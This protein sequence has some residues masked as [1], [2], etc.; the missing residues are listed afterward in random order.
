MHGEKEALVDVG[1]AGDDVGRADFS[2]K[3]D[4]V[5]EGF[6]NTPPVVFLTE[7]KHSFPSVVGNRN[8]FLKKSFHFGEVNF[9]G[10]VFGKTI[11]FYFQAKSFEDINDAGRA[12]NKRGFEIGS[13]GGKLLKEVVFHFADF[14]TG[15][16]IGAGVAGAVNIGKV[17][18]A[19]MEKVGLFK[20]FLI[21]DQN[22]HAATANVNNGEVGV[23]RKIAD[24]SVEKELGLFLLA[25]NFYF[26]A[27]SFFYFGGNLLTGSAHFSECV[28][29]NDADIVNGVFGQFGAAA[30]QLGDGFGEVFGEWLAVI[31]IHPDAQTGER[32]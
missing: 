22:L 20:L 31:F 19:G 17:L 13:N 3:G 11:A 28:G 29:G 30:L 23:G 6:I 8:N 32:I 4:D 5:E 14:K 10:M 24:D 25:D 2:A 15:G 1:V 16:V 7:I 27:G 12:V 26:K 21:A 9:V 18:G